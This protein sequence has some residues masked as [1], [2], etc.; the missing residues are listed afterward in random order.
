MTVERDHSDDL[1]YKAFGA[2]NVVTVIVPALISI[3]TS[4]LVEGVSTLTIRLR[5]RDRLRESGSEGSGTR[6]V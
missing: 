3:G 4:L 2:A 1:R 6:N 5:R